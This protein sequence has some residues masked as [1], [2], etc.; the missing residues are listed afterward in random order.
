M[1][2]N[3]YIYLIRHG[4]TLSNIYNRLQGWSDTP[5]TPKGIIQAKELY[6]QLKTIQFDCY[7]SS[8]SDR[9]YE[10][11]EYATAFQHPIQRDKRLREMNFGVKEC[12]RPEELGYPNG[13]NYITCDW[14]PFGGENIDMLTE[15]IGGFLDHIVSLH[16]GTGRY[17][18]FTH[19]FSIL[20]AIRYVDPRAY[21]RMIEE[22]HKIG[23]CTV[24]TIKWNGTYELV[25]I[26]SKICEVQDE[27]DNK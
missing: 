14:V 24:T 26:D 4:E 10:T 17:C 5:L 1:R 22:N 27:K 16:G 7:Y 15:R 21:Q 3:K 25:Q 23:N 12:L 8:T 19:G 13:T 6:E 9:A 2:S 11:G 20:A 18:C